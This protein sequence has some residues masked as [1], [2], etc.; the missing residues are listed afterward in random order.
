[1]QP[2]TLLIYLRAGVPTLRQR[3]DKRARPSEQRIPDGY[4]EQL[5]A[6]G[7]EGYIGLEY[8]P[9]RLDTFDWLPRADRGAQSINVKSLSP[10]AGTRI[11]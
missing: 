9:T 11:Q 8:K 10:H 4:L 3:I 5:F 1:M 6:Q 2:P 7:Y